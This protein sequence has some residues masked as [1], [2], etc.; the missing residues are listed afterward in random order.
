MELDTEAIVNSLAMRIAQLEVDLAV[1]RSQI[2]PPSG[3]TDNDET[4]DG[5]GVS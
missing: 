2:V 1:A 3:N 5:E 4:F